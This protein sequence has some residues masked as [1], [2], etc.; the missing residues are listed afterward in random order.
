MNSIDC[1][2]VGIDHYGGDIKCASASDHNDCQEMCNKEPQCRRWTFT[3]SWP[4]SAYR[5]CFLRS[6]ATTNKHD[7]IEVKCDSFSGFKS[8]KFK[9]CDTDGKKIKSSGKYDKL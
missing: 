1:I 7:P 3:P 8:A 4:H 5:Q 6:E 9:F 2:S